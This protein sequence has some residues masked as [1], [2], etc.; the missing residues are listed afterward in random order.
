MERVTVEQ[1]GERF[2]LEVPEGTSDADIQTYLSQQQGIQPN[3]SQMLTAPPEPADNVAAGMAGMARPLA[4]AYYEGPAKGGVR[5]LASMANIAKQ[6]TPEVAVE[7]AKNPIEVAKAYIQGHPWYGKASAIPGRVA[8]FAGR[9]VGGAL[10]APESAVLLPYNMAAYEQEKIK[11]NPN[12]PEYAD[13]PY[14]M[15]Q[16]GE[17]PVQTGRARSPEFLGDVTARS[18]IFTA[19]PVATQAAAGEMNRRAALLNQRYGS[20]VNAQEQ[21]ILQADRQRQ[22]QIQ[23]DRAA[24]S[25]PPAAQN[26]IERMR[27]LSNLYGGVKQ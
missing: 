14:A 3:K 21:Q 19:Q 27:A 18:G 23:Q 8:G 4:Q 15:V 11:Q 13:N 12:A 5:D 1:N 9:T 17:V 25:Q 2:T 24:L 22:I 7:L 20:M 6:V 26:F 10:T 16:R